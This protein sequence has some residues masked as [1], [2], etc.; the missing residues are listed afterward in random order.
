MID[1]KE[2][3]KLGECISKDYIQKHIALNDGLKKVAAE[4]GLNKQELRR[5]AE[6]ANV[7]TYLA[8]IKTSEDKYLKF[9]LADANLTHGEIV[10]EG[11]VVV[12]TK[13]YEL[14][15]DTVDVE[16]IFA[17]YKTASVSMQEDSEIEN[18]IEQSD[19]IKTG[20]EFKK[21]SN[22][23]QGV[24]EYLND[25]YVQVQGR[26]TTNV[27]NLQDMIKQGVLEGTTYA[28]ISSILKNAAECTGE[29]MIELYRE[30]LANRMPHIDFDKKAEFSGSLP[31]T[32]TQV[33]KLASE[34]EADFLHTLRLE[35]AYETYR[36][37][38]DDLRKKNDSPNMLKNA[39]FFNTAS[40]SFK[41]FKEHPKSTAAIAMLASYKLGKVTAPK[42]K[43]KKVPLS[44]AA[45]NL[46]L[47]Q[48]KVN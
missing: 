9:D 17:M 44:R 7:G 22:Y 39:G 34:I 10:K 37:E 32:E 48:Y 33:F 31:N 19:S 20:G 30:R 15:E 42:K 27:E 1:P 43:E 26:F 47:K 18:I 24:A 40:E 23:L 6:S 2:L 28:D 14:E 8:L 38:Y 16:N 29:P 13:D 35:E 36:T 5:V 46:R 4:H 25:N 11:K 41:W 45:I 3:E 12:P 21:K